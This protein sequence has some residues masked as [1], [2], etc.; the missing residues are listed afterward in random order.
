MQHTQETIR[1]Y[2]ADQMRRLADVIIK[3]I[4]E[5]KVYQE[6]A[7]ETHKMIESLKSNQSNETAE[8]NYRRAKRETNL[9]RIEI[10]AGAVSNVL[11]TFA[12]TYR[13]DVNSLL[14][15]VNQAVRTRVDQIQT[16]K[17]NWLG[18]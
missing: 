7:V 10:I 11:A 4:E 9:I 17:S 3:A 16:Y 2:R 18:R 8:E 12:F 1:L 5:T 14:D 13:I 6:E 15:S